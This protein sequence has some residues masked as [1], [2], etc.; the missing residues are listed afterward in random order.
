MNTAPPEPSGDGQGARVL[1]VGDEATSLGPRLALSGYSPLSDGSGDQASER[2][3]DQASDRGSDGGRP[4]A[5]LLAPGSET[6]LPGLRLRWGAVPILL[7]LRADSIAERARCLASGADDF[8]LPERPPSD[9]LTRLRLHLGLA[10]RQRSAGRPPAAPATAAPAAPPPSVGLAP[11]AELRL[12]DLRLDPLRR[13]ARRGDHALPL[14]EREYQLLLLLLRHPGEVVSRERILTTIWNEGGSGGASNVIEVYVRYLRQKLEQH[15]GQRLIHTVRGQGYCLAER[16][17]PPPRADET[18]P[19][20]AAPRCG[21]WPGPRCPAGNL[22]GDRRRRGPTDG[23]ARNGALV[24]GPRRLA[25]LHRP[26]GTRG[27]T[28]VRLGSAAA[29]PPTRP[30]GHV[31]SL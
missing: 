25:P 8:W 20:A 16:C 18:P 2:C 11:V 5:V 23:A 7:G 19:P 28:P 1:L 9:L 22:R 10:E 13:L 30:T 17:P 27:R 14:T 4:E 29:A 26:G 15:G 12:G 24:P 3:S 21:A 31:V 6:S